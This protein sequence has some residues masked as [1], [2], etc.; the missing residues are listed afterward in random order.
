MKRD[1]YNKFSG[2][3]FTFKENCGIPINKSQKT[4]PLPHPISKICNGHISLVIPQIKSL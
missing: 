2:Q 1:M 4:L 3:L